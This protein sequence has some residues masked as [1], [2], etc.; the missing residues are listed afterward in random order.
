MADTIS[1]TGHNYAKLPNQKIINMAAME[2][3]Q[4]KT[5]TAFS[6]V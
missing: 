2:T 4:N 5:Q 6:L 1:Q 3:M